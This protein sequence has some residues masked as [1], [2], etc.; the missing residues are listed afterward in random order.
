LEVTA[1]EGDMSTAA[2]ASS[3]DPIVVGVDGSSQSRQ[4]LRWAARM[5]E[6]LDAPI[7][8]VSAWQYPTTYGYAAPL[9]DWTPE[10]DMRRIQDHAIAGVFGDERPPDLASVVE[11]GGAARVLLSASETALVLIVGSRGHGGFAG[12]LLGS[13][14][15][16][17][18]EHASCPV[19][20]V[21]GD[22]PPPD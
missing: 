7:N 21:H 20:I 6:L 2:H 1:E 8:V 18:A 16:T 17:V 5:S 22:Q 9:P 12:L 3:R 13:V 15:A 19:M 14:S 11:P 4:A 10:E